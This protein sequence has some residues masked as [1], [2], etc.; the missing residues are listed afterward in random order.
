MSVGLSGNL[1]DFGIA[2]VF[3]LIGQQRKTGVLELTNAKERVQLVFDAGAVVTASPASGRSSDGDP[4]ADMLLRCGALT[5]RRMD[6]AIEACRASAQAVGSL[7][8]ERGWVEADEVARIEDLLTRD[9]IFEVL[10]WESGSFDFR[11]QAVEHEREKSSLLGAEQILMDGLRMI[12]EWRSFRHL[13]PAEDAVYQ[14]VGRFETFTERRGELSPEQLEKAKRLFSLIDGR[15]TARRVIDLSRLG[16]FDGTRLLAEMVEEELV[17]PLHPE[18]VRHIRKHDRAA[19]AQRRSAAA[20]VGAAVA[21]LVPLL[22]LAAVAWRVEPPRP[23]DPGIERGSLERLR[24]AHATRRVRH[25][26]DA[27]RLTEGRWPDVFRDLPSRGYLDADALAAPPG[28]PYYSVNRDDGVVFLA[29]EHGPR[30][31]GAR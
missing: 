1:K 30:S 8:A 29:P 7:V 18:G 26:I 31:T 11:A 20:G 25:A 19:G 2:D 4:L 23:V 12:D 28:R 17:K 13:V 15:L 22:L 14:R 10:R 6:E 9:T 3:Q 16:T 24:E 5:R 21:A 27:F